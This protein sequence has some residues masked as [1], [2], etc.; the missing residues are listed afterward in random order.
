[1]RTLRPFVL[2]V[3]ATFAGTALVGASSADAVENTML[4]KTEVSPCDK[5]TKKGRNQSYKYERGIPNDSSLL[6]E[7]TLVCTESTIDAK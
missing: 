1:M 4:C 3:L 5:F 7:V 2:A 6:R